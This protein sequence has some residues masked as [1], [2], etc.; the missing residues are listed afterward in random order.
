MLFKLLLYFLFVIINT[1]EVQSIDDFANMDGIR[2]ANGGK[3][4]FTAR[5]EYIDIML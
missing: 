3:F 4:G 2:V 5:I 1:N